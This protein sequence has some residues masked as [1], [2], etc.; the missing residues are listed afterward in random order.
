MP[1]SVELSKIRSLLSKF[2]TAEAAFKFVLKL[3][4]SGRNKFQQ[5]YLA[6]PLAERTKLEIEQTVAWLL[7]YNLIVND[8]YSA[9]DLSNAWAA[10]GIEVI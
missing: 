5:F 8:C 10:I 1:K 9:T 6:K 4:P 3:N 2:P 7:G